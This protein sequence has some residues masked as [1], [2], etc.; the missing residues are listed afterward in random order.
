MPIRKQ[1]SIVA[2]RMKISMMA[3]RSV[4]WDF[5]VLTDRVRRN[6]EEY[7]LDDEEQ[8]AHPADRNRQVSDAN[9]QEQKIGDRIVPGYFD[10]PAAPDD[11][12]DRNQCHQHLNGEV[13]QVAESRRQ[14]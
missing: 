3:P 5:P 14:L 12:E 4:D 6:A 9:R 8:Q 1:T 13:E 10:Q 7:P 11:H 2:R